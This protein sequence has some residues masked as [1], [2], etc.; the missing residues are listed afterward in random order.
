M[1]AGTWIEPAAVLGRPKDE[2]ARVALDNMCGELGIEIAPISVA[3]ARLGHD[4]YLQFGKAG[5]DFSRTDIIP[6]A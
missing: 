4:A 2:P 3:Q 6:A 5:E 1:S